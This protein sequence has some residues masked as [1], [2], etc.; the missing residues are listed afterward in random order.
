MLYLI[1]LVKGRAT[2]KDLGQLVPQKHFFSQIFFSRFL[3]VLIK[4][5]LTVHYY[6]HAFYAPKGTLG[7]I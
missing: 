5:F 4:F 3:I 1:H 7:G 2:D 6:P